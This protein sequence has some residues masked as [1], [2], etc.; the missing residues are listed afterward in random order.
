MLVVLVAGPSA[1]RATRTVFIKAVDASGAPVP[2]LTAGDFEVREGDAVRTITAVGPANGPMRLILLIDTS[3]KAAPFQ[4]QMHDAL[5]AFVDAIP[6]PH[7]IGL[8]TM[9]RQARVRQAPI[10]DRAKLRQAI[11][12]M[13]LDGG[14]IPFF[15]ALRD[16]ESRFMKKDGVRWPA[17]VMFVTDGN[18]SSSPIQS[19]DVQKLVNDMFAR[20]T[21]LH[22]M[23]VEPIGP[24]PVTG[25]V[26]TLVKNSGGELVDLKVPATLPGK[27]KALA[28]HLAAQIAATDGMYAVEYQG[29][30][31]YRGAIE[32]GVT[33]AGVKSTLSLRR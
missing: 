30:A 16:T 27:A 17:Y 12:K 25:L 10:A 6:A 11:D 33:K 5:M 19:E 1:Q 4:G 15:D 8:V 13:S 28:E 14:G 29:D 32:A 31:A 3:E 24:T 26:A 23:L 21:T 18:E 9:G 7:E 22:A 2:G 20:G